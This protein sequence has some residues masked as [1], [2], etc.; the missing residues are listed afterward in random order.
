[1]GILLVA[2]ISDEHEIFTKWVSTGNPIIWGWVG[3]CAVFVGIKWLVCHLIK[4]VRKDSRLK[5]TIAAC[6][7]E[8]E[9]SRVKLAREQLDKEKRER[10]YD[11]ERRELE[12]ELK[13]KEESKKNLTKD[14]K[15]FLKRGKINTEIE[16]LTRDIEKIK[17]KISE[18]EEH[19]EAKN[20]ICLGICEKLQE[21]VEQQEEQIEEARCKLEH[22]KKILKQK[23]KKT[24]AACVMLFVFL[25]ADRNNM[26][27][28]AQE[29]KNTL[30]A[31]VDS[32]KELQ[33]NESETEPSVSED[34]TPGDRGKNIEISLD[35][36]ND[37]REHMNYNFILEYEQLHKEI[38]S[39]IA[40]IVYLT[41]YSKDV[42]G[43]KKFL[44]DCR[45][46]NII[47]IVPE[48]DPENELDLEEL[49]NKISEDLEKPFLENIDTG[50]LIQ[51]QAE[52]EQSAPSS[53]ELE[54]IINGRRQVLE[55]EESVPVRRRIYF[56]LANDY[57]RLGDECLFQGKD[58]TQIYYYYR[59]SIY[60]C[61]CAL[62]YEWTGEKLHSDED[63]LNYVRARYQDIL[64]NVKVEIPA[65]KLNSVEKIC[66][67][68]NEKEYA[69]D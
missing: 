65:D 39:D 4:Y 68:L 57:Q 22:N 25:F 41:H 17:D 19:M 60:C 33:V 52:W 34:V 15:S 53:S 35:I 7:R 37:V 59:M 8:K 46:G 23:M 42:M 9:R 11:K 30:L 21:K 36:E 3:W 47:E 10:E 27:I 44:T 63:I 48:E 29:L 55:M 54:I 16:K 18:L 32:T 6:E 14:L 24:V 20:E 2:D 66:S 5:R 45:K 62:G 50:K 51:T 13:R 67:L 31:S 12:E 58:G 64:D 69:R 26:R 40:D 49:L 43:Y 61:Y 28:T 38:D 56:Q 1:M